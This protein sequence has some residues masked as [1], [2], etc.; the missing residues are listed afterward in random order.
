[1]S[2]TGPPPSGPCARR[3][4]THR[5]Q[6]GRQVPLARRTRRRGHGG[7]TK[8]EVVEHGV[9]MTA[10][11]AIVAGLGLA[12]HRDEPPAF[13]RRTGRRP[14]GRVGRAPRARARC[15]SHP[16]LRHDRWRA[17]RS[18]PATCR[19]RRSHGRAV[20]CRPSAATAGPQRPVD[21]DIR[22]VQRRPLDL[23]RA[24]RRRR[25]RWRRAKAPSTSMCR[26]S[27][28]RRH[29]VRVADPLGNEQRAFHLDE[30]DVGRIS[31]PASA[32]AART[33]AAT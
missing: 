21:A 6:R 5:S 22:L 3:R 28:P 15:R 9:P 27:P 7:W 26:V 18:R 10:Q 19:T 20:R 33:P 31:I 23:A 32:M 24:Q 14:T 1:M 30:M 29:A 8:F 12:Q 11:A 13:R 4:R 25:A 16:P 2:A 17:G